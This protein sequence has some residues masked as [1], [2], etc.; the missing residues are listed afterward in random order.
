MKILKSSKNVVLTSIFS[1]SV[2]EVMVLYGIVFL[3]LNIRS[4][5]YHFLK[6]IVNLASFLCSLCPFL[7]LKFF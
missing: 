1:F 4:G 7:E 6:N 3:S 5:C 2:T